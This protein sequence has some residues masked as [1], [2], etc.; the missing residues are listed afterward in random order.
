MTGSS[1]FSL[2]IL[3]SNERE[4]PKM[5]KQ[6]NQRPWSTGWS[7]QIQYIR[8]SKRDGVFLG[9]FQKANPPGCLEA[10]RLGIDRGSRVYL[11]LSL[12][13]A[14]N[15]LLNSWFRSSNHA[16]RHPNIWHLRPRN[17]VPSS[18]TSPP[19]I[20]ASPGTHPRSYAN[21]WPHASQRWQTRSPTK[22]PASR[23]R[24]LGLSR[25]DSGLLFLPRSI[26]PRCQRSVFRL[27]DL[28]L[29]DWVEFAA[30]FGVIPCCHGLPY[31]MNRDFQKA[32]VIRYQR[33]GRK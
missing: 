10:K 31:R 29:P 2:N 14:F 15:S 3:N 28:K 27:Q 1:E 6:G 7:S 13:L 26:R 4:G 17:Y 30:S 32:K 16:S 33:A 24:L 11:L 22:Y 18:T 12:S 23:F 20:R 9:M 25:G 8:T 21:P 5:P 19:K